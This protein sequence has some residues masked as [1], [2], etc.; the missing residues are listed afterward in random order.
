M[1]ADVFG[2]GKVIILAN[3]LYRDGTQYPSDFRGMLQNYAESLEKNEGLEMNMAP[4]IAGFLL[5]GIDA[6]QHYDSRRGFELVSSGGYFH[7]L[8]LDDL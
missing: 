6:E 4:E 5:K 2:P 8:P 7:S 1:P 3:I